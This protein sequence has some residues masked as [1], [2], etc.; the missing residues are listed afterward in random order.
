MTASPLRT[1]S[2]EGAI[3]I[4]WQPLLLGILEDLPVL[5]KEKIAVKFHVTLAKMI[6]TVAEQFERLPIVLS[7]GCF[8]NAYLVEI[9]E[10]LNAKYAYPLFRH[11]KIPP[12]DGGLALGQIYYQSRV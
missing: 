7:G 1:G 10:K 8:Q 5:S 3:E 9:I 11:E 6:F 4:D 12:N 2:R